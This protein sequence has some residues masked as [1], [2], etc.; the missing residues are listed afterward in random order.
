[1][2]YNV[3][4][5]YT[6]QDNQDLNELLE[7][8]EVPLQTSASTSQQEP[9]VGAGEGSSR[10]KGIAI[11]ESEGLR[12]VEVAYETEESDSSAEM[13][14]ER[15]RPRTE[16]QDDPTYV[17]EDAPSPKLA[18]TGSGKVFSRVQAEHLRQQ[19]S[20]SGAEEVPISTAAGTEEG[21]VSASTSEIPTSD[22]QAQVHILNLSSFV[23]EF[24]W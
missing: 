7:T 19:I 20:D 14:I 16:E 22:A 9:R 18:R 6:Q 15:R 5:G 3:D 24:L 10:G 2:L 4:T 17:P 21:L 1:V 13:E 12:N 11:E 23:F 8:M